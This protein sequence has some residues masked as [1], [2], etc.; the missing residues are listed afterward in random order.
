VLVIGLAWSA[1]AAF[2]LAGEKLKGAAA[3]LQA[4]PAALFSLGL[5]VILL[6]LLVG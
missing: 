3:G 2:R 4:A 5:T 1:R 6:W